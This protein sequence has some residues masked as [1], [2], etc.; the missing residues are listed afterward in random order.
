MPDAGGRIV[1]TWT[2][3]SDGAVSNVSVVSS[4]IQDTNVESCVLGDVKSWTFPTSDRTTNVAAYPF[5][6]AGAGVAGTRA[7]AAP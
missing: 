7:D 6:F 5:K 3:S 1:L 2:I 4:T